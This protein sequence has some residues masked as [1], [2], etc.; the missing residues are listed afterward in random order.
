VDNLEV[1]LRR[2]IRVDPGEVV[3]GLLEGVA[4]RAQSD[5]PV[6]LESVTIGRVARPGLVRAALV[7]LT[8]AMVVAAAAGER[9]GVLPAGDLRPASVPPGLWSVV[10][11]VVGAGLAPAGKAGDPKGGCTGCMKLLAHGEVGGGRFGY[12]VALS[13]NGDTALIGA[14]FEN[15]SAGAAWVF[16]RSGSTW[17]EQGKKLTGSGRTA[18]GLF[19]YSVALSA[20]GDTALVGD[21]VVT[22]QGAAWVFTRSGSAWSQQGPKLRGKGVTVYE[23][24]GSRFGTAVALSADGNTALIGGYNDRGG[25][26]AAWVFTR[27]GSTWAEQ[28]PK[29]TGGGEQG[30]G[31]F[32]FSVA[33]AGNGDTALV[34]GNADGN[35]GAGAAWVFTRSGPTWA[36]QGKKLAGSD[37]SGR[38]LF[39]NDVAL[40]F[41]GSTA[42][43][44]GPY[45]DNNV[46]AAWVFT[47]SGSTWAEQGPKLTGGGEAGSAWFGETVALSAAGKKALVGGPYD[48]SSFGAA[49]VF[50]RSGSTWAQQGNKLTASDETGKAGF[51]IYVALSANGNT[52]LVGGGGD[53]HGVGAAWAFYLNHP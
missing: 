28:G 23:G 7:A 40:S 27:S 16:T 17:A 46:G 14:P 19:G 21:Y 45:D 34:G 5:K 13:A 43:V 53:D 30:Y 41:D 8:T 25:V 11:Q 15:S 38:A 10:Q 33:L 12:S 3:V 20:N 47:R 26:G 9:P 2:K 32:G 22:G 18:G 36:Q 24:S 1:S 49:W 35:N 42:L 48:N 37:E 6:L 51:G 4:R 52:G 44:G 31:S 50:G 39:G 29:L